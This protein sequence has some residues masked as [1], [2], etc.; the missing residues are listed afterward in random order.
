MYKPKYL[1]YFL[2]CISDSL[3]AQKIPLSEWGVVP[4]ED[5][6]LTHCMQDSTATAY[7][8]QD[9]GMIK[10]VLTERGPEVIFNRHKRVK[11]F[12]PVAFDQGNLRIY[13]R[14]NRSEEKFE[15]L[16]VQTIAPDGTKKKV[17]SDNVFTET[18]TD[19]FNAKKVFIPNLQKGTIIEYRYK[20][21][22]SDYFTLYDWY[23]QEDIPV[24]WSQ[25]EVSLP[26]Y[27]RYTTFS[28]EP[29][30]YDLLETRKEKP[31]FFSN[32]QYNRNV[33]TYG[34]KHMPALKDDEPFVRNAN[35]YRTRIWFQR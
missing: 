27:S 2:I 26:E 19:Q 16:E 29:R 13:Y 18:I 23:F 25:V 3:F 11:I 22:S 30:P 7:V 24:R 4:S 21:R 9:A 31:E 20:L 1:L 14:S 35:D 34:Y 5:L 32:A 33:T 10:L 17:K 6:T 8:L 15:D 28:R 12:D